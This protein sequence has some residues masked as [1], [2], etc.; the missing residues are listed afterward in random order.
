[1]QAPTDISQLDDSHPLIAQLAQE[2]EECTNA[3]RGFPWKAKLA[4]GEFSTPHYRDCPRESYRSKDDSAYGRLRRQRQR[5]MLANRSAS[6]S[7]AAVPLPG[8]PV[9]PALVETAPAG[10]GPLRMLQV[11]TVWTP[12]DRQ[13]LPD[14]LDLRWTTES[15]WGIWANRLH[16][17]HAP[18]ITA[19]HNGAE[20]ARK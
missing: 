14:S 2:W 11:R 9:A 16:L 4:A 7:G 5:I 6:T 10:S 20:I 15:G 3:G 17:V 13:R 18:L 8:A 12:F 1:M 19:F